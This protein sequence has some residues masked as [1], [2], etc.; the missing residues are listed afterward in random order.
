MTKQ[1][2][3]KAGREKSLLRRHPWVFSGAV[4]QVTGN[5][6]A[7][8][9]I[10]VC[11]SNGDF[12]AKAGW[13]PRSQ[14]RAKVWSFSEEE[15][16]DGLFFR[17]RIVAALEMRRS[18]GF[19][20]PGG[21]QAY[22]LIHAESDGLPGFVIDIYDN[23]A[24][25]QVL[26]AGAWRWKDTVVKILAEILPLAGIYERSDAAV[27]KLEGLKAELGWLYL[28]NEDDSD[29]KSGKIQIQENE[30]CF[31]V[32]F[33]TGHKTGFYLDQRESRLRVGK[34]CNDKTVLNCFCYTGGFS[35]F[36]ARNGAKEVLSV[37]S[38]AEALELAQRNAV[39][40]PG[41]STKMT[42]MQA[43]V[44]KALREFV[45]EGKRFDVI[46]LDPPKFAA[47]ASQANRAARGYKD[48][49]RL[50]F[51]LLNPGG[52][53]ATFSCSGGIDASLFQKI[54]ASAALDAG[55]DASFTGSFIQDSD[56][57]VRVSFPEGMYLKGLLV[58]KDFNS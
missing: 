23:I 32:D 7:G 38:S 57:P 55:V 41:L 58:Q 26:S 12:L 11:S 10:E 30:V 36:A 19:G 20:I 22:R 31:E 3:L 45:L 49:N 33:E 18:C 34:L 44:F 4:K 6:E 50:A 16:I 13:S 35:L 1:L 15:Q 51:E 14:I 5:P 28:K 52:H 9:T 2:I 54:V 43:D 56:H 29:A 53:L 25:M 39:L 48:I 8:D 42:W 24:V 47:T 37:D 21:Q 40:N 46:I 27:R 17:K